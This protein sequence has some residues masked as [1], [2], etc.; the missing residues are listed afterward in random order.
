MTIL[1]RKLNDTHEAYIYKKFVA[2][3]KTIK[4]NGAGAIGKNNITYNNSLKLMTE[5]FILEYYNLASKAL[6]GKFIYLDDDDGL[7]LSILFDNIGHIHDGAVHRAIKHKDWGIISRIHN[8][9]SNI[10]K[11]SLVIDISNTTLINN[12]KISVKKADGSSRNEK[13]S[14]HKFYNNIN[15]FEYSF[16]PFRNI[17]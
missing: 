6:F 16:Y 14:Y 17:M 12:L 11:K 13:S 15:S 10:D 9:Q 7:R 2:P 8:I 3:Q 4:A 5:E 1:C